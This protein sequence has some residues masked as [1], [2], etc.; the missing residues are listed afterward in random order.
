MALEAH[1]ILLLE[2]L[3]PDQAELYDNHAMH[4]LAKTPIMEEISKILKKLV[5]EISYEEARFNIYLHCKIDRIGNTIL[6]RLIK[7][8][9]I[10]CEVTSRELIF[11]DIKYVLEYIKEY[12]KGFINFINFTR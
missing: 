4:I 1:F 10:T 11:K 2:L 7:E 5:F 12:S 6:Q 3:Y 9:A 8:Y